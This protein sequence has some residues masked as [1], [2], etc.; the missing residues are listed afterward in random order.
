MFIVSS[1]LIL[2]SLFYVTYHTIASMSN[3]VLREEGWDN[4]E[5][6]N[7][8]NEVLRQVDEELLNQ[9]VSAGSNINDR[10][11]II[12]F[13]LFLFL[14]F[15]VNQLTICLALYFYLLQR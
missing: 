12:S 11:E 8:V 3:E 15:V 2:V 1:I 13:F 4:G 9:N 5:N 14:C 7:K 6:Y 10:Y